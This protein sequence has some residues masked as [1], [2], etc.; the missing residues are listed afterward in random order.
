V[1]I[2]RGINGRDGVRT[3]VQTFPATLAAWRAP[4]HKLPEP[5]TAYP[6]LVIAIDPGLKTPWTQQAALGVDRALGQDF[7]LAANVVWVRGKHQLGS[8]D[9]NPILPSLGP[10]RR[11]NDV[12]GRAGT[13][14]TVLQ[15]TSW[16]ESWYRGLT[17]SLSKRFS[18][19]YQLLASYTLS[20]AEDLTTDFQSIFPEDM[21]RGRNPADPTGLPL[22][23]DPRREKGPASHD[24]RHR[25]VLSGLVRLPYEVQ[26]SSI[27]TAASGRPYTAL[28][29]ADL[30]GDGNGGGTPFDR[31]RRNPA[32]PASSVGRNAETMA[33][34]FNVD[35]RLSKRFSLGGGAAVEAIAEAFN[36]FDRTNF[37]EINSI[38]GRG[39]FPA[40]P[41]RDP[42]GRVTYGLYEQALPGRQVQLALKV[43]F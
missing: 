9:Y 3:L 43:S 36:L 31:A 12:G 20:E 10:G 28:A 1:G 39:A 30:N 42:Q 37:S 23:F 40:E 11:P 35:L 19:R 32:D 6:S 24:Q 7:S 4:G 22:G 13:S 34:Q 16:G 21:G 18:R 17:L 25:F 15:Y 14:S 26:V 27:V 2:T 8:I 38:F 29:G 33:G 5:A 41:Q